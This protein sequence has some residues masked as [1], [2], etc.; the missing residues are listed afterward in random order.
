MQLQWQ[1]E[2]SF[3]VNWPFSP[4]PHSLISRVFFQI[5]DEACPE[6]PGSEQYA[7]FSA[8]QLSFVV[9][10]D[11]QSTLTTSTI[12]IVKVCS[13]AVKQQKQK[14]HKKFGK[15][16]SSSCHISLPFALHL[17]SFHL[18]YCVKSAREQSDNFHVSTLLEQSWA[19]SFNNFLGRE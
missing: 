12:K 10:F 3:S 4:R 1:S 7:K 8:V 15:V 16:Q 14:M 9:L 6:C 13:H 2:P 5:I 17:V 18:H 11:E 19:H